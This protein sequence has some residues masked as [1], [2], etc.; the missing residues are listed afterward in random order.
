MQF[1]I[2]WG[3]AKMI[4]GGERIGAISVLL[5]LFLILAK[6]IFLTVFCRSISVYKKLNRNTFNIKFLNKA[7]L[8]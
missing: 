1:Y 2:V 5:F 6:T 4:A 7:K 3:H 8:N